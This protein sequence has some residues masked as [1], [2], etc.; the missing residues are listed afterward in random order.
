MFWTAML[1]LSADFRRLGWPPLS[2]PRG[3]GG[4]KGGPR[5]T[6]RKNLA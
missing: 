4:I 6:Q 1:G 5:L 2:P 3:T